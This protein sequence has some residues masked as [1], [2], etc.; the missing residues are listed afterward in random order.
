MA[1][2]TLNFRIL[3][4]SPLLMHN[5][6][7]ADPLNQFSI[8]LKKISGK[9]GKTEEDYRALA[10]LEFL[11]GLYLKNKKPCIP[12]FVM[13][14]CLCEAA[15]KSR[16]GKQALSGIFV[17]EDSELIYDG[18]QDPEK[19]WE[20]E[21]FRLS[22]SVRIQKNR[23]MR[24]RPRFDKWEAVVAIS[25]DDKVLNASDVEEILKSACDVGLCD[26]R[27]KFG[28]FSAEREAG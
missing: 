7:T 25:F 27:P 15:K 2:K 18:P 21:S 22:A 13:E 10:H 19:M 12:G 23:V 24:T 20:D 11:S 16:R 17:N 14:A 1:F 4:V 9:R 28:R 26:W 3:G 8:G 5:G 6:Q